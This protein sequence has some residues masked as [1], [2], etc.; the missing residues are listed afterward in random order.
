MYDLEKYFPTLAAPMSRAE[1]L[2]DEFFRPLVFK[3]DSSEFF[4]PNLN[5]KEDES[6]YTFTV[7]LPGVE[8]D[9]CTVEYDN[10]VLTISG[11]K[12]KESS[13]VNERIHRYEISSGKFQRSFEIP[14][15]DSENIEAKFKD[16]V[17]TIIAP[18][19]APIKT[20][21]QIEIK[22]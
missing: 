13:E 6:Q 22:E 1:K 4:F 15:V 10:G 5:L 20:S 11:E 9:K 2:F 3:R 14:D 7:E 12:V 19:M 17:L 21:K 16:G 8:K 18:K